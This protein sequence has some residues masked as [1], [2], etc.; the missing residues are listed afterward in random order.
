MMLTMST[1]LR[2]KIVKYLAQDIQQSVVAS[3]CG[4]TASYITQLLELP[5]VREEISLLKAK[6]LEVAIE[7]D[8]GLDKLESRALQMVEQKLP[9]VKSAIEA[10][11]I[12]QTLNGM[13]RKN[14]ASDPSADAVAAQ[15]VTITIPRGANLLFKMNSDNQVIEV[16]GRTMAPLPS[17][18]LPGLQAR[19]AGEASVMDLEI[20]GP[21][22]PVTHKAKQEAKD[23][24]RASTILRDLTTYMDGVAIVL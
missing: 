13:K 15:Q 2:E 14:T 8:E 17:K 5:E 9:Y 4:V 7:N 10:V 1:S 19:L 24:A 18:A 3:S 22:T 11:K 12:A 6:R 16:E 21:A 20:S 23:S